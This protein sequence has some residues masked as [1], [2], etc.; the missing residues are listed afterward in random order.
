MD[1]ARLR[2][3]IMYKKIFA[4]AL[5]FC[6]IFSVAS[7][8]ETGGVNIPDSMSLKNGQKLILNGAGLRTKFFMKIYAGALYTKQ[9]MNDAK[10]IIE[11]DEPMAIRMHF[12]YDGVSAKKLIDAW[13]EGFENAT[14]GN[15]KP[16]KD[17]V[18]KFNSFFTQEAKKGDIYDIVYVPGQGV[19]V[20]IKGKAMGTISGL[21][22]KKAVFSIWLGDKPADSSLKEGMLGE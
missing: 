15:I 13:N 7:A 8:V 18:D 19:S 4:A 5:G 12:I 3:K 1:K 20:T 9:K 16:I 17:K 2:G 22:F 14:G 21:E 10:K 6:L 11:A